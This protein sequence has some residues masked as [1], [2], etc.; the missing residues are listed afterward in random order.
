MKTN[1]QFPEIL[2][3][4][5]NQE[6]WPQSHMAN[7]LK[8]SAGTYSAYERGLSEPSLSILVKLS[9]I[10]NVSIDFLVTGKE[11]V[12]PVTTEQRDLV[13]VEKITTRI[14]NRID[15]QNRLL[16]SISGRLENDISTLVKDYSDEFSKI[17]S[18]TSSITILEEELWNIESC[19]R[20]T[21][22]LYPNF[23]ELLTYDSASKEY[24]KT[25]NLHSY[26]MNL[27]NQ[28]ECKYIDIF[29]YD[30]DNKAILKYR[31]LIEDQCGKATL[32][33]VETWKC[34][35]PIITQCVVY[36]LKLS[37]FKD[38][39]PSLFNLT[40]DYL[41]KD[42]YLALIISPHIEFFG[43]HLLADKEHCRY[44]MDFFDYLLSESKRF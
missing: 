18:R 14:E 42:R 21:R 30:V 23:N 6:G 31:K 38:N 19:S 13:Q 29:A 3:Y 34:Q 9:K 2:K 24:I 20:K 40:I 12:M 28:P 44:I 11:F 39:Y 35:L 7:K 22:V 15:R 37:T 4:L 36:E 26:L 33:R 8:V 32:K 16:S 41:Y 27:R 1:Y 17:F 10:F 43:L 5:R 25:E